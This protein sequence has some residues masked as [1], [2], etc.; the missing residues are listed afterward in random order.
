MSADG[1][2][3]SA[4]SYSLSVPN[5]NTDVYINSVF[6]MGV[7]CCWFRQKKNL[8]LHMSTYN[9]Y[10]IVFALDYTRKPSKT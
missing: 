6:I 10:G 4:W 5:K 3:C 1:G 8:P 2:F 9:I 7:K